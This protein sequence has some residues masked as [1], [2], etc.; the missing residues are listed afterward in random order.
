MR[1]IINTCKGRE[2]YADALLKQLPDAVL[3]FDDFTDMGKYQSTVWWNYQRGWKMAGDD[4]CIQ[5]DDDIIL[6]SNFRQKIAEAIEKHPNTLIQFFSMRNKDLT[7]GTRV[8][9]GS[10]FM[11]QQCYYMPK[12]MAKELVEY[13]Y[14]WY[15]RDTIHTHSP[16]DICIAE[17]L[18]N[19]K[20]NYIIWCPNLVDHM[21]LKSEI[22]A[23][24]TSKRVSK[25]FI[26]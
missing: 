6:T 10:T 21:T 20:Q 9:H 12:G 7:I 24:R 16:N 8:E 3:N 1:L 19:T 25:T 15:E 22:N 23:K 18:K 13:S 11:M 4:A 17:Y 5:F 2:Q 14:G 26:P